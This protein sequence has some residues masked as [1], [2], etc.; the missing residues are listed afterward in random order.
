[1]V[2][3]EFA[4]KRPTRFPSEKCLA[5]PSDVLARKID[6]VRVLIVVPGYLLGR[7]LEKKIILEVF[8]MAFAKASH[9]E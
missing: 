4:A 6:L 2:G 8:F 9:R 3:H 5:E 1:L 7:H